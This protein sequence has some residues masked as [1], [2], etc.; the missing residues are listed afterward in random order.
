MS[1]LTEADRL[2]Y[3]EDGWRDRESGKCKRPLRDQVDYLRG[4]N[5]AG[6]VLFN[7]RQS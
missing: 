7:E 1:N 4:W 3:Y 6:F 5:E 2:K